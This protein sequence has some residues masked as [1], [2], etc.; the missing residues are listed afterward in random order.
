MRPVG[1]MGGSATISSFEQNQSARTR[2]PDG[3]AG[4]P[5]LLLDA[6]GSSS[7]RA[8]FNYETLAPNEWAGASLDIDAL[9]GKGGKK[10]A[11]DVS[12]YD[13]LSVEL[14][15]TGVSKL[16]IELRSRDNGLD[17]NYGEYPQVEIAVS[18]TPRLYRI[19]LSSF[20]V[21]SW[22]KSPLRTTD[23]LKRLTEISVKALSNRATKGRVTVDNVAFERVQT[24]PS[25][26]TAK[27][28]GA[29]KPSASSTAP[30]R[31][32]VSA[33]STSTSSTRASTTNNPAS[34]E[35][36]VL[37]QVFGSR[38]GELAIYYAVKN[39]GTKAVNLRANQL[40]LSQSGRDLTGGLRLDVTS[41]SLRPGQAHLGT[42]IVRDAKPGTLGLRWLADEA[43]TGRSYLLERN[44]LVQAL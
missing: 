43:D 37:R 38:P 24:G 16:T 13:T 35:F 12:A 7:Q 36:G 31:P 21:P 27:P 3:T 6:E 8:F 32:T 11:L 1:N 28:V 18:S 39:T 14:S 29:A 33:S 17:V 15:A 25:T 26:T 42:I 30:A 23:V 10:Q 20:R 4:G 2:L 22:V 5:A 19:A 34:L 40:K 44:L 41:V 9:P